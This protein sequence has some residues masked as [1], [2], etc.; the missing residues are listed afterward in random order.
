MHEGAATTSA[1]DGTVTEDLG[2]RSW[3]SLWSSS[4]RKKASSGENLRIIS[5]PSKR[6][7]ASSSTD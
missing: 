2:N 4:Y 7:Y 1:N 3:P 6:C 5:H